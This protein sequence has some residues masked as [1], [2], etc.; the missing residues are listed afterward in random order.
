MLKLETRNV[1][2]AKTKMLK[3]FF[4]SEQ[5][6]LL[7]GMRGTAAGCSSAERSSSGGQAGGGGRRERGAPDRQGGGA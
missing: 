5:V 7:S 1:V 4:S 2:N 3:G 6:F